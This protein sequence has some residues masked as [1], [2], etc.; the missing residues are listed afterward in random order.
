MG[1]YKKIKTEE[2]EVKY[3]ER[4]RQ[5]NITNQMNFRLRKKS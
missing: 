3:K 5:Q 1:R 4:R 2:E